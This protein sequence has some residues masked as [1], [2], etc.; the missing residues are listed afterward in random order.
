MKQTPSFDIFMDLT[1]VGRK[2]VDFAARLRQLEREEGLFGADRR[3]TLALPQNVSGHDLAPARTF[4]E[5]VQA[6]AAAIAD[7]AASGRAL[8]V[9]IGDW[10]WR[11]QSL[12]ALVEQ[13]ERDPMIGMVQP[14]FSDARSRILF[15]LP[16]GSDSSLPVPVA[17]FVPDYYV[18]PEC[19]SAL[20][21]LT[22]RGAAAAPGLTA[23]TLD[24]AYA[25][26]L[27]GLRRRGFRNLICNRIVVPWPSTAAELYPP[28]AET[29]A[30]PVPRSDGDRRR[31][32]LRGMPE[33]RLELLLS[34]AF[35]PE[36]RPRLL[37][38]CRGMP[39]SFNGTAACVLG[40]LRGFQQ[41]GDTGFAI[42]V[43][44]SA[45][46]AAFH[47]L[48]ATFPQFEIQHDAPK[49]GFLAAIL[50]NQPWS[51]DAVRDLHAAAGLVM[52]NMLDTIAWDI[53][54]AALPGLDRTWRVLG[55][56][57]DTIFFNSA[58]SR[59]RYVFRFDPDPRIPLV[60]THHSMAPADIVRE[61]DPSERAGEPYLAV[62][63]NDYDHKDIVPTL[64][65]LAEAFPYTQIVS[66]GVKEVPARN[67]RAM[68]SGHISAGRMA[69]LFADATAIV[70][71]S[72]Y[73]GFGLPV[74]EALAYGKTVIVRDCPLWSELA[75][76]T[77]R[78]ELIRSFRL[79]TELVAAV[80]EALHDSRPTAPAKPQSTEGGIEPDWKDC[81][82][83]MLD[84]T[85]QMMAAFDGR[86]W[87]ARDALLTR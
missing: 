37:L 2:D 78:P 6:L 14:R 62:I 5:P 44:A 51:V 73:E 19:L 59:D 85:Q 4:R 60:V 9:I 41:L 13:A 48:A 46:A 17:G 77:S 8:A 65:T 83:K 39:P 74:A 22:P 20:F 76:L 81:A 72:H 40:F 50:L 26:L 28:L 66:V 16:G 31:D 23:A 36:G 10:P 3:V 79:D 67:V 24:D 35:S 45:R 30:G 38:D 68:E 12:C 56:M 61:P 75:Q 87:L 11:N 54:Y 7:A 15:E 34:T 43:L 47:K 80:G 25:E 57:A 63:G 42:T 70:F 82:R 69:A 58:Y 1:G 52:F 49:D 86:R 27:R 84:A 64:A 33:R 32:M 71:P 21:L 29:Y 53:I 18:A 55:Q